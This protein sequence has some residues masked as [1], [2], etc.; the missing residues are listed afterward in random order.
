MAKV[1]AAKKAETY[2]PDELK[3]LAVPLATVTPRKDNPRKHDVPKIV[4]LI[5][6]HGFRVPI[7]IDDKGVIQSGC[8]RY[9]AA[10]QLGMKDIPAIRQSFLSKEAATAFAIIENKSHEWSSWDS[11]M[12][13]R[14][15]SSGPMAKMLPITGFTTKEL[16]GIKLKAETK[17]GIGFD[18]GWL[19]ARAC[20]SSLGVLHYGVVREKKLMI[21]SLDVTALINVDLPDETVVDI[22]L[23]RK[24]NDI[25]TA[26][27]KNP[28]TIAA[29][30]PSVPAVPK[31]VPINIKGDA[32]VTQF[33]SR[34]VTR[35]SLQGVC[36]DEPNG[37][38]FATDGH[39]GVSWP[40]PKGK[41]ARSILP[42]IWKTIAGKKA[43]HSIADDYLVS[44]TDGCTL[45]SKVIDGL[46]QYSKIIPPCKDPFVIEPEKILASVEAIL[47]FVNPK[48]N[49]VMFSGG[50]VRTMKDAADVLY[51]SPCECGLD[52]VYNGVFLVESLKTAI[53]FSGGKPCKAWRGPTDISATVFIAGEYSFL[54]MP[55]RKLDKE[56]DNAVYETIIPERIHA[57]NDRRVVISTPLGNVNISA[58][59]GAGVSIDKAR[60]ELKSGPYSGELV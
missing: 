24:T 31:G 56:N 53:K 13:S 18:L 34:D 43:T 2:I 8:G 52:S 47:P 30:F 59:I 19:Y 25:N 3:K 22:D 32:C 1:K 45:Y 4:E 10:K 54:I 29:D 33:V 14:I 55:L 38:A 41:N 26:I 48:T 9:K 15:L 57:K 17:L 49:A 42:E 7:I 44:V 40:I 37:I 20:R 6:A 36:I 39:R 60:E 12:L 5:K 28:G 46:P 58:T 21:S 35:S 27:V 50:M 16:S 51:E 23:Y 11:D